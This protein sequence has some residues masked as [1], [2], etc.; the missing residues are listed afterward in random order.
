M[1]EVPGGSGGEITMAIPD[2]EI[3]IKDQTLS[4]T[5]GDFYTDQYGQMIGRLSYI[6]EELIEYGE[7]SEYIVVNNILI[8]A[9]CQLFDG[10]NRSITFENAII[11]V[12][13]FNEYGLCADIRVQ[14]AQGYTFRIL[15][16]FADSVPTNP[17]NFGAG[18]NI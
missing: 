11:S 18:N 17:N 7:I 6:R 8:N 4:T 13:N 1:M 3:T 15:L 12:F 16:V 14:M 5:N 9:E 10:Y 2:V